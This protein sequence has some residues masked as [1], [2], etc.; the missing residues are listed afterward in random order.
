MRNNLSKN[1]TTNYSKYRILLIYIFFFILIY[2]E[3]IKI[4]GLS[5]SVL[6][7]VVLL[8]YI[9]FYILRR[10]YPKPLFNKYAY[11]YGIIKLF[12]SGL[13]NTTFITISDFSRFITF[14]LFYDYVTYKA[15]RA[16]SIYNILYYIS[17]FIILSFIPF[18]FRL[19]KSHETLD[20]SESALEALE[21]ANRS[22]GIFSSTHGASALIALALVFIT[23]HITS[24][25]LTYRTK[26][27]TLF[28]LCI[29]IW[30]LIET[31]AR[32]GWVMWIIG[33]FILLA[34]KNIRFV[35]IMIS[36]SIVMCI[37]ISYLMQTNEY[38]YNRITDRNEKGV[39]NESDRVGSG[40]LWFAS[41][42]IEFW[43][44]TDNIQEILTG[45][46]IIRLM[47]YQEQKTGL[48]IYCHNG[49]IDSLAQNGILGFIFLISFNIYMFTYVFRKKKSKYRRLAIAIISMY[50]TFQLLQ[51]G[52]S[53]YSD[54]IYV[55]ILHLTR[56]DQIEKNQLLISKKYI[57]K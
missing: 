48:Y 21:A 2:N 55:L 22:S 31:Y 3:N 38:F 20:I 34:R 44:S 42:G 5:L 24:K 16:L 19:L 9:F 26:V 29:G 6:W 23:Y 10:K 54:I 28:L 49:Y 45:K 15:K 50:I 41:N 18:L 57:I 51:G 35:I 27:Y 25:K 37:G 53:P 56:L 36:V 30:A 40:R 13:Y 32:G 46:G 1:S 39:K 7:K 17:Q 8:I 52:A 14:P 33:T 43:K 11:G 47:E 12:N 4:V